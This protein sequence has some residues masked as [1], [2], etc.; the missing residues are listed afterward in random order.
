ME[1]KNKIFTEW[2]YDYTDK[3]FSW[4]LHKTSNKEIAEDLVQ[5]TFLSAY[6][7]FDKFQHKSTVYTWLS[8]ILNNKIIDYY[9]NNLKS[10]STI[11]SDKKLNQSIDSIFTESGDWR[12]ENIPFQIEEEQNLLDNK[13]F[14]DSLDHC[15]EKLPIDWRQVIQAKYIFNVSSNQICSDLSISQTNYWKIMQR[16]KLLLKKCL[17]SVWV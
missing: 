15:Y 5:D 1:D 14:L 3:L 9:R 11:E 2:V 4:A 16:A 17:E 7:S 13:E 10:I 6:N 12:N 8:G